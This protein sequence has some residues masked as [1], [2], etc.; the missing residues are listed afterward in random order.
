M[1]ITYTDWHLYWWSTLSL[2]PRKIPKSMEDNFIIQQ[3]L[4]QQKTMKNCPVFTKHFFKIKKNTYAA[5]CLVKHQYSIFQVMLDNFYNLTAL[6]QALMT[7]ALPLN[8]RIIAIGDYIKA[9]QVNSIL[10]FV[11]YRTSTAYLFALLGH[12]FN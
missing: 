11:L 5:L 7:I 8:L 2:F 3:I 4:I 1:C 12:G 10:I 9:W 6:T